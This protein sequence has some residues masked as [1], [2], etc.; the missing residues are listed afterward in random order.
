[1]LSTFK[2][3]KISCK[4]SEPELS[5][6]RDWRSYNKEKLGQ[7]QARHDWEFTSDSVQAYWNELETQLLGIVDELVPLVAHM[8]SNIVPPTPAFLKHKLKI[9]QKQQEIHDC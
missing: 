5:L 8:N 6:R 4:K 3:K 1:M 9:T 2:E 7:A